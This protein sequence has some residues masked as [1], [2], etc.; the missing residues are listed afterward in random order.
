[1]GAGDGRWGAGW[2]LGFEGSG[3]IIVSYS[4]VVMAD[5]WHVGAC[6]HPFAAGNELRIPKGS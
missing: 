1:M 5:A 2:A 4:S 3:A 6:F